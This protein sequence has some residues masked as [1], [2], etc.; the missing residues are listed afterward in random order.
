[1]NCKP[2]DLAVIVK[3]DNI[4]N[5]GKLVRVI[6]PS[7]GNHLPIGSH[8]FVKG[9][10]FRRSGDWFCWIVESCS[11]PLIA[12]PS[13]ELH[14]VRPFSDRCLRPIRDQDGEDEMIRIAGKPNK[15]KVDG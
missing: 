10:D 3:S 8:Y 2:G 1:M 6:L 14:I 9:I 5:I 11:S 15:E 7:P 13:G 4:M 12:T